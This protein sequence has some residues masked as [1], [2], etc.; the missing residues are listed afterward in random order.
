MSEKRIRDKTIY[1]R[2]TDS[3]YDLISRNASKCNL[4]IAPYLRFV[5]RSPIINNYDY[6]V[7]RK[8][9]AEIAGLRNSIN[10]LI[11]T[12]DASN[13]YLPKEIDSIVLYMNE[14]FKSENELLRELRKQRNL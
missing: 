9:T 5:G 14:I 7:I 4:Q 6:D 2:V 10:N 12:I 1:V 3:E 11:F 8:H 13:N